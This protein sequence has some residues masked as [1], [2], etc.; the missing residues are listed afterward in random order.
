MIHAGG[1]AARIQAAGGLRT[2]EFDASTPLQLSN[3]DKL[4]PISVA[5]ETY[6]AINSERSNA[7][8]VCHPLGAD[9]FVAG[10]NPVTGRPAWWPRIVGPGRPLDT[11]RYFVICS[12]V[13]GGAMG[14]TG[15]NTPAAD[16][17]PYGMRFPAIAI[18]DMVRA[19]AMLIEAL[20]VESLFLVIGPGMGGMQALQWASAYP[21]RVFA[22]AAIATA[23]KQS[24]SNVALAEL[25][26]QAIMAD[27]DWRGGAYLSQG[28]RPARG[29]AI[30]RAASQIV[31]LPEQEVR[32]RAQR[33]ATPLIDGLDQLD[34]LDANAFLYLSQAMDRWDL[35][36]DF[37]GQLHNAF[38][39]GETRYALFAFRSDWRYP[40]TEARDIARALMAAGAPASYLEIASDG[41]HNAIYAEEPAFESALTAFVDAAAAARG[42]S[43]QAGG[44]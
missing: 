3:G 38:R 7:V 32:A 18:A 1:A 15:P 31:G 40:L 9:Q 30:A 37:G 22:S 36:A 8:L 23:A 11:N 17:K 21:R 39:G 34:R 33:T 44:A 28:V 43:L 29:A 14:T 4:S 5:F 41:G 19:Q 35:A 42:M 10:P 12:N 24:A 27:P 26:R 16:G 2:I 6:G 20:G 13:L 25:A